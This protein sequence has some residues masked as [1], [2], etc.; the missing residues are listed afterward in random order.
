MDSESFTKKNGIDKLIFFLL[1]AGL[2]LTAKFVIEQKKEITLCKPVSLPYSGLS[3]SLPEGKGWKCSR[4]WELRKDEFSSMS[5]LLRE[6]S[7]VC[8]ANVRYYLHKFDDPLSKQITK[9]AAFTSSQIRRQGTVQ[10]KTLSIHWAK[11]IGSRIGSDIYFAVAQLPDQ[12]RVTL[13]LFYAPHYQDTA[14]RAFEAVLENLEFEKNDF[15]KNGEKLVREIKQGPFAKY[16]AESQPDSYYLI[17]DHNDNPAGF[18]IN[19]KSIRDDRDSEYPVE[20]ETMTYFKQPSSLE[21][22]TLFR[23]DY[24]LDK[25]RWKSE[26]VRSQGRSNVEI[27]MNEPNALTI[28]NYTSQRTEESYKLFPYTLPETASEF[29]YQRLIQSDI[30]KAVV[31]VLRAEGTF[32]PLYIE[33]VEPETPLEE[34]ISGVVKVKVIDGRDAHQKIYLDSSGVVKKII[35]TQNNGREFIFEPVSSDKL[36]EIFPER[37]QVILQKKNSNNNNDLL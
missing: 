33:Q 18:N 26:T 12:R 32:T 28:R 30:D 16:L 24:F 29:L 13:E 36:M 10:K 14:K 17:S 19:L 8:I 35:L 4:K 1:L 9:K 22:V 5:V 3:V 25:F 20:S 34:N 11:M 15:L 21:Q 7:P 6:K 23:S 37:A 31:D 27:L 2:V